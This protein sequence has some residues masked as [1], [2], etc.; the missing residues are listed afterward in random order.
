LAVGAVAVGA[1]A[2]GSLV[3]GRLGVGRAR[4]K[5]VVID[6]LTVKTLRVLEKD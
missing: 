4:F 1:L 6:R 2:I 5:D 3:I